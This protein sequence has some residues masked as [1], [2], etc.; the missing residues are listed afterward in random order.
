MN[1]VNHHDGFVKLITNCD[2]YMSYFVYFST[3]PFMINEKNNNK[4]PIT[5]RTRIFPLRIMKY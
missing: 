1:H 5:N 4:K 2:I 3:T